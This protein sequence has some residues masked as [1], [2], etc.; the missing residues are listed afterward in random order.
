MKKIRIAYVVN[1]AAFFVSHRLPI[2]LAAIDQGFEVMLIAG[3]AGVI[4]LE[5]KALS[6][7]SEIGFNQKRTIWTSSGVN[8]FVELLGLL[9][10]IWHLW[11]FNPNIVHCASPKG[12]LYGGIASRVC[13]VP[14]L[15]L[16]ISGM[17]YAFTEASG[18]NLIRKMVRV[19]YASVVRLAFGHSNVRVV[20]QN[21]DDRNSLIDNKLIK[22]SRVTLIPGS[23]VDI[24][25]YSDLDLSRDKKKIVLLPARMLKDKGVVEFVNAVKKIKHLVPDWRFVLAGAAGYDNPSAI[26]KVELLEWCELGLIEWVGHVDDIVPWLKDAAIV[27]LPSYREGMPKALLEAAVAGCAIVTTDVPG[28]RESILPGVTGDMVRLQ[29]VDALA[30]AIL[31]LIQDEKRRITYGESGRQRAI[32]LFSLKS[33]IFQTINLYKELLDE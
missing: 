2:A 24:S 30:S 15:F 23:G 9:Q 4:E 21:G 1:N 31:S 3:K 14:G 25:L 20:V 33:V 10:L 16:S 11:K 17:G 32:E 12:V 28:C 5:S 6:R 19:I 27:C 22:A 26:S 18:A 13:R 7:L 29:D 8:P